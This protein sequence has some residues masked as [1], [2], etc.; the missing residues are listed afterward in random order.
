MCLL[1]LLTPLNISTMSLSALNSS[2]G[3][4]YGPEPSY[5]QCMSTLHLESE[6][7]YKEYTLDRTPVHCRVPCTHSFTPRGNLE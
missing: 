5:L 3:L 6:Y 7:A 4:L 1:W 2:L